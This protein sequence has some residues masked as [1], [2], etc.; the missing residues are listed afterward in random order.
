LRLRNLSWIRDIL[1]RRVHPKTISHK[2]LKLGLPAECH[3]LELALISM[4]IENQ[5]DF[6]ESQNEVKAVTDIFFHI[7]MYTRL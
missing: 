2:S 5:W 3:S 7:L 4:A 6:G 1:N